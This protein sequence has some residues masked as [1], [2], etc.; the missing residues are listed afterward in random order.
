[1]II[2]PP[3]ILVSLSK[4]VKWQFQLLL[5]SKNSQI[6]AEKPIRKIGQ[7][8]GYNLFEEG[9]IDLFC[10]TLDYSVDFGRMPPESKCIFPIKS[11]ACH[12]FDYLHLLF[13][14]FELLS[15]V[16]KS[17]AMICMYLGIIQPKVF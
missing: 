5:K 3:F 6:S 9:Q 4:I 12:L 2:Q 10:L 15:D 8:A 13:W 14:H 17:S 7:I 16:C 11:Y 1:M